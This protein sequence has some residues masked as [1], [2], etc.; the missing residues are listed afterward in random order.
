MNFSKEQQEKLKEAR[1]ALC[2]L[3][4]DPSSPLRISPLVQTHKDI[5]AL[6]AEIERLLGY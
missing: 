6:I 4:D 1:L 2:A 5:T 3:T